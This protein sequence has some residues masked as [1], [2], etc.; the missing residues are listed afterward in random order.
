MIWILVVI[1]I[2][3]LIVA[4]SRGGKKSKIETKKLKQEI[5]NMNNPKEE[6]QYNIADELSKLKKLL[7][8]S[9]IT[10]DEFDKQKE[11]LLGN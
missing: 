7:D 3:V 1:F 5:E 9:V 8:E 11:K 6:I 10:K 4:V 2:I